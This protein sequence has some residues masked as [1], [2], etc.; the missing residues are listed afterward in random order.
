MEEAVV[1]NLKEPLA[2]HPSKK[3]KKRNDEGRI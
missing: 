3:S 2:K 1:L